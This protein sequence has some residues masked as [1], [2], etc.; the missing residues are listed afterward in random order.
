MALSDWTNLAIVAGFGIAGAALVAH[1]LAGPVTLTGNWQRLGEF[2]V[3]D[4][5]FCIGLKGSAKRR[6]LEFKIYTT[7]R[8]SPLNA[9]TGS[10]PLQR[11]KRR[12]GAPPRRQRSAETRGGDFEG[13]LH[14][15]AMAG[16]KRAARNA[17]ARSARS[18]I[19][20][21][22][23]EAAVNPRRCAPLRRFRGRPAAVDRDDERGHAGGERHDE[24]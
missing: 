11:W 18:A 24:E 22:D 6:K 12:S 23:R 1:K 14:L 17:S 4:A 3:F 2:A 16:R 13:G 19:S 5:L 8:R 9:M 20:C 10:R 21:A 15:T 7:L